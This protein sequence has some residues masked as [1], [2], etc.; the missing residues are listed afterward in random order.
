MLPNLNLIKNIISNLDKDRVFIMIAGAPGSGKTTLANYI[1]K[2]FKSYTLV[3][4]SD[5]KHA[6]IAEKNVK[7][8]KAGEIYN[9]A[10]EQIMDILADDGNV[11]YDYSNCYPKFR[12]KFIDEIHDYCDVSICLVSEASIVDCINNLNEI[13]DLQFEVNEYPIERAHYNLHKY[14][15]SVFEGFDIVIGF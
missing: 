6:L 11:I 12:Q 10:K 7:F 13:E 14:P 5:I 1:S 2:H 3:S 8:V 15:P 9:V 4:F